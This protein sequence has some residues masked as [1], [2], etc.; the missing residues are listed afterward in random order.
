M[1][2]TAVLAGE[3]ES[4]RAAAEKLP[5]G[6]E[7]LSADARWCGPRILFFFSCYYGMERTL[8]E[9]V[10][11]CATDE[12]GLTAMADLV[13][14]ARELDLDPM[15]VEATLDEIVQMGRPAGG[16]RLRK[17]R[18]RCILIVGRTAPTG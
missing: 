5:A 12:A 17:P 9:V 1:G 6:Y 13:R 3:P 15:P 7:I 14:A 11:L 4:Q 10:Q 8:D 18:S 16:R 2:L